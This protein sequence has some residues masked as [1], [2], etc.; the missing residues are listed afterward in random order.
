MPLRVENGM[1][2]SLHQVHGK[3][4][5]G[6]KAGLVLR[7][8]GEPSMS[9][10]RPLTRLF[11]R[12][13]G[14]PLEAPHLASFAGEK[15]TELATLVQAEATAGLRELFTGVT[16]LASVRPVSPRLKA[17]PLVFAQ[18]CSPGS[19]SRSARVESD[20]DLMMEEG[21]IYSW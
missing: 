11:W 4:G 17:A 6:E 20:H 14:H 10:A 18:G 1:N 13:E 12:E 2:A 16:C 9:A 7:I 19:T 5:G 15:R 3:L 8:A 21:G